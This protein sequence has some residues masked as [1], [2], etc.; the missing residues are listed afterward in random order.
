MPAKTACS[1]YFQLPN[2][3]RRGFL[4]AGSLGGLGISLSGILRSEAL[5]M[6]SSIAPKAKSVILLWLQG[7]VSHHDTFDPKPYAPAN[8]RGELNTIQTTLPGV[9]FTEHL[10]KLAG[11]TDQLAIIRSVTHTES[12]HQRGS[13]YMVEGRRPP[14]ATGVNA[15]GYPELGSIVAHELGMRSGLPAFV[16][17][18]GNDFTS[19]FTGSGYLP[20]SVEA[21]RGTESNSLKP[22]QRV[23][24]DRFAERV[25]LQR[26]LCQQSATTAAPW[27]TFNE[28]AI[29]IISTGK[30][31]AAFDWQQESTATQ[32]R[33]GITSGRKGQMGQLT[34]TARRLIEAGVR[35][36]TVGRNSWDH[37]SNIFPLLKD[38]VPRVDDA[39][40]GLIQD[41]Q[42]RNLLDE[43]LVICMT[44]Y[45][46][47]PKINSQAGRDHWPNAF[48]ILFAGAG[49]KT[50]QVIGASDKDGAAVQDRPVSPEEIAATILHLTGINPHHEYMTQDG[51]PIMYVDYAQP[52][53][54][55]LS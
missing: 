46:R 19:R 20:P 28:Q 53:A 48:S 45:G 33:Y 35:Y 3:S 54:E 39:M 10:P 40:S 55:L 38:R 9:N 47:T 42:E 6:G 52:I 24:M 27:D 25:E 26:S 36:V 23:T 17:I 4:Q 32:E 31:A 51:R 37:H 14:K 8:I 5:A 22:D 50:G 49:I 18:P 2:I 43:T 13:M 44:E 7:G 1:S 15:S 34:L 29:E 30:G 41:L 21:F 12:A 16:S 11:M